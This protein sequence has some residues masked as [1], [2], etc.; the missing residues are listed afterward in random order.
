M[1][2]CAYAKLTADPDR[3]ETLEA[4]YMQIVGTYQDK[5]TVRA[6][7]ELLAIVWEA[8]SGG[9]DFLGSVAS[10]LEVL[11][12]R[13]GQFMTPQTVCRMMA[14]MLLHDAGKVIEKQ[15]YITLNEPAAGAGGMVLASADVL[16]GQ[17]FNPVLNMLVQ[18]I[19]IS[20]L[21]FHM[22]FVQLTMKG[23]PALVVRANTLS[24]EWF[25][26]AWT[27]AAM[28][29]YEHHGHLFPQERQ[30]EVENREPSPPNP[31]QHPRQ[32]PLF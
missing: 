15:G 31:P 6:Y 14:E 24:Q 21:C 13:N 9:Q 27:P 30:P 25:E 20:P 32:L 12:A 22:C 16:A 28:L 5:D 17:G 29:F 1:A 8:V 11:D 23:I 7:P 19:D 26:A 18:A 10:I 3:A 2:Y 4:R